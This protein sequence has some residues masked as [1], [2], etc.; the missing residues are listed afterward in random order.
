MASS[1]VLFK[2]VIY[3]ALIIQLNIN[4]NLMYMKTFLNLYTKLFKEKKSIDKFEPN[5]ENKK[6]I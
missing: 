4:I 6:Y 5:A 1:V 3:M 2:K